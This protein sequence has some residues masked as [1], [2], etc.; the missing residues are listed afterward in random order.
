MHTGVNIAEEVIKVIK[1][2]S[3]GD[4]LSYFILDNASN[5]N[6][7][8]KA[9]AKAFRFNPIKYYL[10]CLGYIINLI[11]HYLL[12]RFNPDLFKMEEVLPK[13]LKM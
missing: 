4:Q 1:D 7:A 11:I 2:F 10:C 12:F 13:D 6:T 8:I 5:N 9:I 3:I